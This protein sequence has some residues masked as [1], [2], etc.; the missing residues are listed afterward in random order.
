V[1]DAT[2]LRIIAI[3]RATPLNLMC[4]EYGQEVID[5]AETDV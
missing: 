1:L 2:A 5:K 3:K 4:A